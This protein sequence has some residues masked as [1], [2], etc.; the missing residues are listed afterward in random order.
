MYLP[1]HFAVADPA[2]LTAF[3]AEHPFATLCGAVDGS[4]IATHLPLLYDADNGP[5]GR[6]LGHMARQNPH[7]R[8]FESGME[9][10]AIFQGPHA[11]VSPTWYASG[12]AV[13]TWNYAAVH[14]VGRPV[15]VTDADKERTLLDRL[16]AAFEK[17]WSL[18]ELPQTYVEGMMKGI[19]TFEIPLTRIEGKF[20]MSQNRDAVDRARVA[21]RLTAG[22]RPGDAATAAMMVAADA[23]GTGGD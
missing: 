21:E 12:P 9:H 4:P 23:A 5:C 10:L 2:V 19:V 6:L 16:I 22:T 15:I 3:I 20:K 11:Y 17:E 14:A 8:G 7:W 1:A 13:P 18:A